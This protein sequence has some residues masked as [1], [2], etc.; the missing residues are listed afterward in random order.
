MTISTV[1]K[2]PSAD[3]IKDL[4]L[5]SLDD[6]KGLDIMHIPLEGKSSIADYLIIASGSSGRQIAAMCD[7][8]EEK[9]KKAGAEIF[10][11]EGKSQG[12]WIVIDA[13]DVVIHLFRPEVREFYG[14]EK[15]W[16]QDAADEVMTIG[17]D[18]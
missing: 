14:L 13:L 2:Q 18:A 5:Q 1:K 4:V 9:L 8:L 12:D 17:A 11:R 3:E 15:M 10:G 6:D 16:S 7:H